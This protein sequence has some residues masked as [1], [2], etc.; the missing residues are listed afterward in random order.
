MPDSGIQGSPFNHAGE[1]VLFLKSQGITF[2]DSH[3]IQIPES[4]I[5]NSIEED[6]VIRAAFYLVYEWD[7]DYTVWERGLS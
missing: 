3:T 5:S 4:K 7:Y 6:M 1:A 2:V